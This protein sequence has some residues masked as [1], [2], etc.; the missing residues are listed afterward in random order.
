MFH[1]PSF[2]GMREVL[3]DSD[4]QLI[5]ECLLDE[6]P[7]S[8]SEYATAIY[9]PVLADVAVQ[10]MGVW[11]RHHVGVSCL[12]AAVTR[13]DNYRALDFGAPF[14]VIAENFRQ[15]AP[16]TVL[17]DI[18]V[19][20][21]T[22]EVHWVADTIRSIGNAALNEVFAARATAS[23]TARN[24]LVTATQTGRPDAK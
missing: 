18:T 5:M 24:D 3:V 2:Q 21:T 20:D 7:T 16:N 17:A 13:V 10:I 8:Y 1:G 14:I 11:V 6:P 19:C 12:P 22:G 9:D 15:P 23:S 4:D